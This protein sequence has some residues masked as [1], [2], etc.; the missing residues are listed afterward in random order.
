MVSETLPLGGVTKRPSQPS[1][2]LPNSHAHAPNAHVSSY[3]SGTGFGNANAHNNSFTGKAPSSLYGAGGSD[4]YRAPGDASTSAKP[5]GSMGN[6]G[7]SGAQQGSGSF[8]ALQSR[9]LGLGEKSVSPLA[10]A[11]HP[12]IGGGGGGAPK[13]NLFAPPDKALQPNGTQAPSMVRNARYRPGV[14]PVEVM[15]RVPLMN[16]ALGNGG[17]AGGGGAAIGNGVGLPSLGPRG[18][19]IGGVGAGNLGGLGAVGAPAA[20]RRVS[21]QPHDVGSGGEMGVGLGGISGLPA[22]GAHSHGH[23]GSNLPSMGAGRHGG[24]GQ[25]GYGL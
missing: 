20:G 19:P 18:A 22:L 21:R 6:G 25:R 17:G 4:G 12:M 14:D 24:M 23:A 16:R 7:G 11:Q 5:H 8:G 9:R 13:A 15:D 10:G 2:L 1:S 3:G